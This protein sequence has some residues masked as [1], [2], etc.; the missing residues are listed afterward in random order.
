MQHSPHFYSVIKVGLRDLFE[1]HVES[2]EEAVSIIRSAAY[3]CSK[4]D[5]IRRLGVLCSCTRL[6]TALDNPFMAERDR[7]LWL[8]G[9]SEGVN[10]H[11]HPT[12]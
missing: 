11:R 1:G 6:V 7:L 4:P 8:A 12:Q 9:Y 2:H 3:L 10:G 5:D